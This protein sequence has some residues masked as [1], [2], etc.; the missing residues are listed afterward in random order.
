[1]SHELFLSATGSWNYYYALLQSWWTANSISN[2]NIGGF[3]ELFELKRLP[4]K[5]GLS[6]SIPNLDVTM[7]ELTFALYPTHSLLLVAS[8]GSTYKPFGRRSRGRDFVKISGK[9]SAPAGSTPERF[10]IHTD[11]T[12]RYGEPHKQPMSV[13]LC[14]RLFLLIV[15]VLH[16]LSFRFRTAAAPSLGVEVGWQ[17]SR[18]GTA[19]RLTHVPSQDLDFRSCIQYLVQL[20]L[21]E[22]FHGEL[23]VRAAGVHTPASDAIEDKD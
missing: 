1:M 19:Q 10:D 14:M 8:S 15:T 13:L 23:E 7:F 20:G 5:E 21:I 4:E 11:P 6:M 16:L 2:I 12:P 18:D 22:V 9:T 17:L 3:R